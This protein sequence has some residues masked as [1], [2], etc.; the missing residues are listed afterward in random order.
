[1]IRNKTKVSFDDQHINWLSRNLKLC[2][3]FSIL[4]ILLLFIFDKKNVFHFI[5]LASFFILLDFF[6]KGLLLTHYKLPSHDYNT[7]ISSEKN[8]SSYHNKLDKLYEIIKDEKLFLNENITVNILAEKLCIHPKTISSYI[9]TEYQ[10]NFNTF[11]NSF[12]VELAATYLADK[13]YD[14]LTLDAI[15]KESGF[16]TKSV[17]YSAFKKHY[18][19][20]PNAYKKS[21]S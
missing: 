3:Y 4:S 19:L 18:G 11:I 15:S 21:R 7:N 2:V 13:Q 16:K 8:L 17:F 20:S 9:N 10:V 14:Y 12:R 5:N 6:S 1:M